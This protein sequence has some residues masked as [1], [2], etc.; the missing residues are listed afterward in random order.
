MKILGV[1]VDFLSKSD[2]L[3]AINS[4]LMQPFSPKECQSGKDHHF[5][6]LIATINPEFVVLAQHDEEFAS[7]LNSSFLSVP[8]GVGILYAKRFIDFTNRIR[9]IDCSLREINCSSLLKK[10]KC[11][12]KTFF[13]GGLGE[14]IGGADLIYDICELANEKGYTVF[15]LGGWPTNFWGKPVYQNS[16]GIDLATKAAE[17]L[18]QK[19]SNLKIIGATSQFNYKEEDDKKTISYIK[20]QMLSKGVNSIDILFVCYGASKQEKW[21]ERNAHCIPTRIALG[22]GG[23]F[24][25]I[26]GFKKRSPKFIIKLNLEWLFRLITQPWRIKRIFISCIVFPSLVIRRYTGRSIQIY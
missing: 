24:D 22:L 2:V 16:M 3:E 6:G 26:S 20:E 9:K 17:S 25:Y 13:G 12:L 19:Y 7:I 10:V 18:K 11:I 4:K 23:T 15:L 1:R 21:I 8:D 5:E 14:R